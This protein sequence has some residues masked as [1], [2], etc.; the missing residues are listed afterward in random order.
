VSS[1]L[2]PTCRTSSGANPSLS[3]LAPS[4]CP[5][6]SSRSAI[7]P[8]RSLLYPSVTLSS[9]LHHKPHPLYPP[10]PLLLPLLL[11]PLLLYKTLP[12]GTRRTS[13]SVGTELRVLACWRCYDRALS[14]YP[15]FPRLLLLLLLLPPPANAP[16]RPLNHGNRHN[17]PSLWSWW[18]WPHL[19]NVPHQTGGL[20]SGKRVVNATGSQ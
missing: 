3:P 12:Q 11:P 10:L 8:S 18:Y 16:L 2:S 4:S 5:P 6:C 19:A 13:L 17:L 7:L 9:P 15:H 1:S 20:S 14:G